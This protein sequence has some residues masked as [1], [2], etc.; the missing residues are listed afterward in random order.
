M[1]KVTMVRFHTGYNELWGRKVSCL[2]AQDGYRMRFW[3]E[4]GVLLIAD[5]KETGAEVCVHSTR[6]DVYLE[7]EETAAAQA[8]TAEHLQQVQQSRAAQQRAGAPQVK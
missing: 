5:A 1:R 3:P 2:R 8:P 4:S 7:A 6:C